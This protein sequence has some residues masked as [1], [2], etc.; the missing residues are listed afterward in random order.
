MVFC[1]LERR[2]G[3]D[4]GICVLADKL[5]K[6]LRV[7][8]WV[9]RIRAGL[10]DPCDDLRISSFSA[11]WGGNLEGREDALATLI[12]DRSEDVR[13]GV[14]EILYSVPDVTATDKLVDA[15]SND[16]SPVVRARATQALGRVEP[17]K[18]IPVLLDVLDRD[19]AVDADSDTDAPSTFAAS[20]MDE[21]LQS[22]YTAIHLDNG[23]C[24]LLPHAPDIEALKENARAYLKGPVNECPMAV[25]KKTQLLGFV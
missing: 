13:S 8:A 11:F 24:Q 20:A 3:K 12:N 14:C 9:E 7:P 23:V 19:G 10:A 21:L 5:R 18:A 17:R 2:A 4:S 15:A 16:S 1:G 22:D 6:I 25:E